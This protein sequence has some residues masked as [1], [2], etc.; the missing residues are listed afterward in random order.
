MEDKMASSPLQYFN[1]WVGTFPAVAYL[2][3]MDEGHFSLRVRLSIVQLSETR[4]TGR[5]LVQHGS[6]QRGFRRQLCSGLFHGSSQDWQG[7]PGLAIQT[8]KFGNV[9]SF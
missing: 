7:E 1:S 5:N 9:I 4:E 8:D 6:E 3:R 2:Q